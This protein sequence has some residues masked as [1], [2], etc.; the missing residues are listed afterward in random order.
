MDEVAL[1]ADRLADLSADNRARCMAMLRRD[2]A[3]SLHTMANAIGLSRP[4][5]KSH[6]E[7]LVE[8][9][10]ATQEDPRIGKQGGR[11]AVTYSLNP[12]GAFLCVMDIARHEHR[13]LLLDLAGTVRHALSLDVEG[14]LTPHE[15]T[16]LILEQTRMFLAETGKTPEEMTCFSVSLGGQVG[17]SGVSRRIRERNALVTPDF[18]ELLPATVVIENDLKAA[19][20]AEQMIGCATQVRD[21]VYAL[22]WHQSAAGLLLDGKLR[23]GAHDLAGE[24]NLVASSSS[25]HESQ[26]EWHSWPEVLA[27]ALR[28][29][30]GDDAALTSIRRFCAQAAQQIAYLATSVDP[31]MIVLGGPLV[32]RSGLIVDTLVDAL[33]DEL[34]DG[35]AFDIQVSALPTWG[36]ALGAALRGLET[37][38][39]RSL[40]SASD[41]YRLHNAASLALPLPQLTDA[42]IQ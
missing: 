12:E 41:E 32:H 6:L 10:F 2:N 40:G 15:R 9:G 24:L 21:A 17:S 36:P 20:Y 3:L 27:T 18:H 19:I 8:M 37:I 13:Y 31:E 33:R 5:L 30:S 28:A 42:T 16:A 39:F 35:P 22:V 25:A 11:P 29:E 1:H 7:A 38:E 4:T 14:Q 26:K 23:R 34:P